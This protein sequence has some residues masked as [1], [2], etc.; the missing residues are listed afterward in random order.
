[1]LWDFAA[2]VCNLAYEFTLFSNDVYIEGF[3]THTLTGRLQVSILVLKTRRS[4]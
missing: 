2:D 4:T 1:M 3:F